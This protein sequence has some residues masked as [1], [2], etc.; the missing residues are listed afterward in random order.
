MF[1]TVDRGYELLNLRRSIAMLSPGA[2]ALHREEA[3]DLLR[4]LQKLE[5]RVTKLREGLVSLLEAD[6]E[7]AG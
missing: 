2:W 5:R 6:R 3:I 4:E 7:S 1:G